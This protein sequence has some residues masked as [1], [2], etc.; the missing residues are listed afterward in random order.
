[1]N[2]TELD[3]R[4]A[5]VSKSLMSYCTARTSN[6]YDAEDLAQDIFLELLRATPNLRDD[7]AFYGFMWSVAHRVY[8]RWYK[9]KQRCREYALG[10]DILNSD[11]DCDIDHNNYATP[12]AFRF[13]ESDIDRIDS[14]DDDVYLL[15]RELALLSQQFRRASIL[16]YSDGRSCAEIA[17]E[18]SVSESMVKYLLFRSR[19]I[20]K[21]GMNMERKLG[22]LSYNPKKLL[23][24]Y[25]GEG[26]NYFYSYM[27][28]LIRQ[29]IILACFNDQLTPSEI[30]L[31]VGIPLPYLDDEI[32]ELC[33]RKLLCK[34]GSRYSANIVVVDR[35][36]L[37][38]IADKSSRY[39]EEIADKITAF[40]DGYLD[41]YRAVI[42]TRFS[43]NTLRWQLAALLLRQIRGCAFGEI[44]EPQV[45][46]WGE[47]AD[48]WLEEDAGEL[49]SSCFNYCTLYSHDNDTLSFF[50]YLPA[51]RG[52]H[53][54]FY[55]RQQYVD[56]FCDIAKNKP[57]QFSDYDTNII[58][59]LCKKG[60][61]T[62]NNGQY[63]AALPVYTA[64]QYGKIEAAVERYMYEN[65]GET[66]TT[67]DK[68]A[69][70]VY[71]EHCPKP[72]AAAA[73]RISGHSKFIQAVAKPT[74]LLIE[75]GYLNTDYADN[76]IPCAFVVI[77]K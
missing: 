76:E 57:K 39:Y 5:D 12:V 70:G 40:V 9:N 3:T 6:Q 65:L 36:C 47:R 56:I 42:D 13:D 44:G 14:A 20:I 21:E 48:I 66:L 53:H 2:K 69:A 31:E 52:D 35:D 27:N 61:I 43:E 10:D 11:F 55:Q 64:A 29:N 73:K 32:S 33:A 37:A 38:E 19:Q 50:D 34:N 74:K 8:C 67:I 72:L 58:R 77:G 25:S 59:E 22:E 1:M 4:L 28:N 17:G 63:T 26:P 15:R 23:P 7:N 62:D 51:P 71:T 41:E 60:Y 30:G 54:D 75:R 68:I 49:N 24:R 18:L 16:Y 45:T 46:G